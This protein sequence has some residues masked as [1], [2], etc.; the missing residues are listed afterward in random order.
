MC[1]C[2]KS[3][4][5]GARFPLFETGANGLVIAP[6][7]DPAVLALGTPKKAAGYSYLP[8]TKE[9]GHD[10]PHT[11]EVEV[12]LVKTTATPPEVS[13]WFYPGELKDPERWHTTNGIH[14]VPSPPATGSEVWRLLSWPYWKEVLNAVRATTPSVQLL[15]IGFDREGQAGYAEVSLTEGFRWW[16]TTAREEEEEG[17]NFKALNPKGGDLEVDGAGNIAFIPF[18]VALYA[19][20]HTQAPALHQDEWEVS[21]GSYKR[22][23]YAHGKPVMFPTGTAGS[24]TARFYSLATPAGDLL[25][26]GKVTPEIPVG[27]GIQPVVTLDALATN[28][29]FWSPK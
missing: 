11:I 26:V 27:A 2:A 15:S 16:V 21:Y 20:L 14:A 12:T 3:R 24:G 9:A 23:V 25:V 10:S 5:C 29:S 18:S 19:A 17:F 7:L 6:D 22:V 13:A 28:E 4:R 8:C 1:V